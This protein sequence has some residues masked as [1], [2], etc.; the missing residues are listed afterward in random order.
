M[1]RASGRNKDGKLMLIVGITE[2]N[3]KLLRED[4]PMHFQTDDLGLEAEVIIF[5]AESEIKLAQIGR[6]LL[7]GKWAVDDG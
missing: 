2:N 1:I 3:L 6:D 5:Y 7:T 4:K